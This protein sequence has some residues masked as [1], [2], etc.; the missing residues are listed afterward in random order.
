[1]PIGWSPPRPPRRLGDAARGG[2]RSRRSCRTAKDMAH[3]RSTV[4][5]ARGIRSTRSIVDAYAI[6][7]AVD[8]GRQE[9]YRT[10]TERWCPAAR[11]ISLYLAWRHLRT[12]PCRDQPTP[13][14]VR[15]HRSPRRSGSIKASSLEGV[16]CSGRRCH[17]G[18]ILTAHD[19]VFSYDWR[20][21]G[22]AE[23][24]TRAASTTDHSGGWSPYEGRR[25]W[26]RVAG[27]H[28]DSRGGHGRPHLVVYEL[29]ERPDGGF[30]AGAV[31]AASSSVATVPAIYSATTRASTATR[32]RR[33]RVR[34]WTR[35][36]SGTGPY[37]FGQPNGGRERPSSSAS[38]TTSSR[39]D[40]PI[41]VS[42]EALRDSK[43]LT[44]VVRLPSSDVALAPASELPAR[45]T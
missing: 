12:Q 1:M 22:V 43:Q 32:E 38:R 5:R 34:V 36:R 35:S 14:A 31:P 9:G 24:T 40:Y 25:R 2:R 29:A 3:R 21:A 33:R 20:G 13:M 17:D 11:A 8:A 16:G 18:S 37:R 42:H 10:L 26:G 4:L 15:S 23:W 39:L 41:V 19:M 7:V 27:R 6:V 45:S 44:V 28:A 30:F